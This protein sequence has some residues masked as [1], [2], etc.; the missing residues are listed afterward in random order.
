MLMKNKGHL[1]QLGLEKIISLKSALNL[2]LPEKLK[3]A[4]SHVKVIPRSEFV[5]NEDKLNPRVSGFT[6]GDGCFGFN[7]GYSGI[8]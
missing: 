5:V 2:G 8:K 3:L 4:F 1:T 6:E 7:L